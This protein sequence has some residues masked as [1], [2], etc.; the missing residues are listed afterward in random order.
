MKKSKQNCKPT[1]KTKNTTS[2]CKKPRR[3][4]NIYQKRGGDAETKEGMQNLD[5]EFKQTKAATEAAEA[6]E[7]KD[8]GVRS[9]ATQAVGIYLLAI[10]AVSIPFLL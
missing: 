5:T 9:G 1:K 7:S 4:K 3:K 2:K 6:W 8:K 10:A